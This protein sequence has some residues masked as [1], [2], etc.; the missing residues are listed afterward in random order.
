MN[1]GNWHSL[2]PKVTHKKDQQ[3]SQKYF[4]LYQV[5]IH[6]YSHYTYYLQKELTNYGQR[7]LKHLHLEES[8]Q[9]WYTR[10]F[11]QFAIFTKVFDYTKSSYITSNA[12]I[13]QDFT[14]YLNITLIKHYLNNSIPC[15][16]LL[17]THLFLT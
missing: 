7:L 14:Y 1:W 5:F 9:L 4:E 3:Y 15:H 11:T 13:C 17:S 12:K 6:T 16:L 2:R 8:T 10:S